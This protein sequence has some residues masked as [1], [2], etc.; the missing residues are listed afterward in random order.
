MTSDPIV[1]YHS[2]ELA[3]DAL[4]YEPWCQLFC[5]AAVLDVSQPA[6][7]LDHRGMWLCMPGYRQPFQPS[8]VEIQRRAN[9]RVPTDLVRACG[10]Q[11]EAVVFW[12]PVPVLAAMVCCLRSGV[13]R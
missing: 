9:S 11:L 3:E 5:I 10:I 13:L 8:D 2:P 7:F 4:R 6:L 1:L 12:M